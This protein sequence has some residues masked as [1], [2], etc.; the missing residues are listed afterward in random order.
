MLPVE[1][2]DVHAAYFLAL[3]KVPTFCFDASPDPSEN[4]S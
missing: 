1:L 2:K 4:I 3:R